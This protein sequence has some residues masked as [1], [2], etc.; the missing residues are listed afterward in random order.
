MLEAMIALELPNG[1][2]RTIKS[3]GRDFEQ[4]DGA[5]LE[6]KQSAAR[7][8]RPQATPYHSTFSIVAKR[9]HV[10]DGKV[11]AENGRKASIYVFAHHP[12]WE[13][14]GH[15]SPAQWQFYVVPTT[16]LPEDAQSTSIDRLRKLATPVSIGELADG[17]TMIANH[18][19]ACSGGSI[20]S[21][22]RTAGICIA[23]KPM[24]QKYD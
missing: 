11:I 2:R 15:R 9:Y 14:A 17:I 7:Q 5:K 24:M 23:S 19:R 8:S 18:E 1:R 16:E 13:S 4:A 12:V 3:A 22:H 21:R 10:A 6:V 20:E